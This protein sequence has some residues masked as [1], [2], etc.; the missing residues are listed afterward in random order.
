MIRPDAPVSALHLNSYE[1]DAVQTVVDRHFS[2]LG[3]DA[4]LRPGMRVT[5]KPNLVMKRTPQTATTTHPQLVAAIVRHLKGCGV[6]DVSIADSPG[7]LYTVQALKGIY[8]VCGMEQ[9][10]RESGAQLNFDVSYGEVA[11]PDGELCRSFQ[12]I[13]PI[14]QADLVIN[15]CKLKTHC[16]TVLSGG[17]KNLFGCVPG[18]MKPEF[19]YRFPDKNQFCN[20]LVDLCRTV[21]PAITFADAVESMEGN[22]PSGGS[23]RHTG[24]TFCSENPFQLD[25]VAAG[26][27]TLPPQ[28]IYTLTNGL[29]RGLCQE[30][31]AVAVLGDA[32]EPVRDFKKPDSHTIDF[33]Q[34]VPAFLRPV[35][36]R[37]A[38]PRP[39]IDRSRCVGCGKCAES[40]PPGT[41]T[42]TAEKKA[43]IH[44]QNCIKCF[45]CHEM[46]PV[47]AI[48]VRRLKLFDI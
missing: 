21:A 34:R 7:G 46:C 38:S 18:L 9:A 40:C 27:L 32:F 26:F 30:Q 15:V 5:I 11:C 48:D 35:V 22:G 3:L 1:P 43:R 12:I 4:L 24:M 31:D 44:Y 14:S 42:I 6:T 36:K 10:A 23:V 2:L 16:M 39:K 8:A 29:R 33:S 37:L 47:R 25:M 19:H 20:M 17:V 45:C 13:H 41:I 28:D